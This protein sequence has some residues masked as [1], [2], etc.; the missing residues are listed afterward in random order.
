MDIFSSIT[1]Y[2]CHLNFF[3]VFCSISTFVIPSSKSIMSENEPKDSPAAK[4][5]KAAAKILRRKRNRNAVKYFAA[6]MA[7]IMALF[8][9]SKWIR[10][11]YIRYTPR[12]KPK[13]IKVLVTIT[14]SLR[15]VFIQKIWGFTSIGHSIIFLVYTATILAVTFKDVG[16]WPKYNNFA[17]RLG[18]VAAAHITFITFLALKNTPL[19]FLTNYSYESLRVFHK[20]AG[21]GTILWSTLHAIFYIIYEAQSNSYDT[22]LEKHQ[23]FG[24]VAGIAMLIILFTSLFIYRM[25][26]EI[27]YIVHIVMYL[28]ILITVAMHR[29]KISDHTVYMIFV[30]SAIWFFDRLLRLSYLCYYFFGNFVTLTPLPNGGTRVLMHRSSKFIESGTHAFLWIPAIRAI[31]THPFTIASV[32]GA[33][34]IGFVVAACDGFTNDLHNLA[35]KNPGVKLR[36]SIDGPYGSVVEFSRYDK[37][38]FIAGGSGGAFT[39]GTAIETMHRLAKNT[40]VSNT[41]LEFIWVVREEGTVSWFSNELQE[42]NSSPNVIVR[43]FCT[44]NVANKAFSGSDRTLSNSLSGKDNLSVKVSPVTVHG[45][46]EHKPQE[47]E[48]LEKI[49]TTKETN[50]INRVEE[51]SLMIASGRPDVLNIIQNV[52]QGCDDSQRVAVVACGP[53]SLMKSTRSAVAKCITI[54][55][56]GL[57][58]H[59]EEFSW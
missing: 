15:K 21:Y 39:F 3:L 54:N 30:A 38:I 4:A 50:S 18:W 55:G 12:N 22:L 56:P 14:R 59:S 9:L 58:L 5:A 2:A 57:E 1:E 51:N 13:A 37:V 7:A 36:A 33:K 11:L 23:I 40:A 48:D 35:I 17:K 24:I 25:Q 10:F 44:G 19:A 52:A 16:G 45:N 31:E 32:D 6:A 20:L 47:L 8:I 43:L 41:V 34:G 53:G 49:T 46:N 29:P 42:L 28:L 27:W 26:Y